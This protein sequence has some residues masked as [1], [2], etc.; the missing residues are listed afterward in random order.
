MA[1]KVQAQAAAKRQARILFEGSEWDFR[2][3]A[4]DL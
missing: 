1:V 2:T 3:H 4:A